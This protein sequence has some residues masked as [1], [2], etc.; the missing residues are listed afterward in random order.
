[1]ISKT[2]SQSFKETINK[3]PD[4]SDQE[5]WEGLPWQSSG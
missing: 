4:Y 3:A 2:K 1:M 5:K